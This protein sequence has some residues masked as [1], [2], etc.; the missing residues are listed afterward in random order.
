MPET[1]CGAQTRQ[2]EPCRA[3]PLA[4]GFC[5]THDPA[6]A[7]DRRASC[8][9]GGKVRALKG[10]RRQLE[11]AGRLATFLSDLI[12][13][14]LAGTVPPDVGRTVIYGASVLRQVVETSELEK[15]LEAL[16]EAAKSPQTNGGQ[17]WA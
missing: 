5:R 1:T 3:F 17:R 11:R 9:K 2:G 10:R 4:S 13:D 15:R 8:S 14:I 7:E 6:R 16:E 12:E